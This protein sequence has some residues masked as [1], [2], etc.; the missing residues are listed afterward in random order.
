MG[1]GCVTGRLGDTGEGGGGGGAV[2]GV[3]EKKHV[4]LV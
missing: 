1:W 2:V 3:G 4:V